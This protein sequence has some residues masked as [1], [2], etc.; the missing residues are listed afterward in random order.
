MTCQELSQLVTDH[1]E[2]KLS[3][4]EKLSF[5]LHLGICIHC[6][7]YLK[8][9]RGMIRILGEMGRREPLPAPSP[10]VQAELVARFRNYRRK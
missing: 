6:R 5:Q 2:G 7:A 10:A 1:L 9:M 3:F 4:W 8:Q